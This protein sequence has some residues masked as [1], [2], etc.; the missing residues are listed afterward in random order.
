MN[1]ETAKETFVLRYQMNEYK[2]VKAKTFPVKAWDI[3][4]KFLLKSGVNL[5]KDKMC[6]RLVLNYWIVWGNE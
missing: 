3:I 1:V 6:L 5:I 2:K 4:T